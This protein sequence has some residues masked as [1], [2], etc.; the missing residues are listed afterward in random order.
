MGEGMTVLTNGSTYRST[1]PSQ[2]SSLLSSLSHRPAQ[3]P[4][5]VALDRPERFE[6]LDA[7]LLRVNELMSL[8]KNWDSYGAYPV[9]GDAAGSLLSLLLPMLPEAAEPPVLVPTP[10]GGIQAS[11]DGGEHE[12]EVVIE[13]GQDISVYYAHDGLEEEFY[14][15]SSEAMSRLVQALE[16]TTAA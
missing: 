7:T 11:W 4:V 3:A 1:G 2:E 14:L 12:V 10:T 16:K 6:W 5:S 9:T 8:G 13:S 15:G